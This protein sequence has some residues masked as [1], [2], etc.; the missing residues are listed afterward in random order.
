MWRLS[1]ATPTSPRCSWIGVYKT[2]S[3][4]LFSSLA[5]TPPSA[6]DSLPS[7]AAGAKANAPMVENATPLHVA[8]EKGYRD[9]AALLLDRGM[10][11]HAHPLTQEMHWTMR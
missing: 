2:S 7:R 8:A 1:I 6:T 10:G 3:V 4:P 5:C 9:I 11:A